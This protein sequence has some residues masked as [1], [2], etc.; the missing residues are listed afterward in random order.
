MGLGGKKDYDKVCVS[1]SRTL[2]SFRGTISL[3]RG[4]G[5][6]DLLVCMLD[7]AIYWINR[8]RVNSTVHFVDSYLLDSNLSALFIQ[9]GPGS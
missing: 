5:V 6:Q 2:F 3:S 7:K 4:F 8:Y 9:L 1:L